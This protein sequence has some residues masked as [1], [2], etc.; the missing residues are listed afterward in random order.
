MPNPDPTQPPPPLPRHPRRRRTDS[1]WIQVLGAA[2]GLAASGGTGYYSGLA[3]IS[4]R[5][6]AMEAKQAAQF[7]ELQR[8]LSDVRMDINGTRSEILNILKDQRDRQAQV[9]RR[10]GERP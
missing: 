10:R 8:K 5:V 3:A 9:D 4:E 2:L 1:R 6:A 7:E